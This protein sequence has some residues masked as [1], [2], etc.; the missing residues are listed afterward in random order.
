MEGIKEKVNFIKNKKLHMRRTYIK[1][2]LHN[3]SKS[4]NWGGNILWE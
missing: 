3:I 2:E 1:M 4:Y